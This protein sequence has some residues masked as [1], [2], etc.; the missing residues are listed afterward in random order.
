MKR[1]H[2]ILPLTIFGLLVSFGLSACNGGGENKSA[3]S[4]TVQQSI[5]ITAADSKTKL[6]LGE[7]V[8]LTASVDGVK[9]SSSD[10]N[11]ATISEK[12]L[13]TSLAVGKTTIKATKDGYKDGSLTINVDLQT[14]N[15]TAS[16]T[17]LVKGEKIT[18]TADQQGVKWE[19]ADPAI[20]TVNDS[21]EVTG[22]A[23]GTVAIKASK[24]GFN[25]GSVSITVTRPAPTATLHMEDADHY[26]ADGMWG[27]DYNGTIY[28]PGDESPVYERT[29][30]NASDGK[31]IAYM[32]NGDKEILTF[33][34]SVAV[35]A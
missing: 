10:L 3:S 13:V 24:D 35:K 29:S 27:T 5:K 9:W 11:V 32:D 8:Q 1:K 2:F 6:I 22:V 17:S 16:A 21:G 25:P 26:T 20:A 19:S 34:S 28:G 31:C 18:V 7:T 15:V 4:Q 33:N 23:A 14:T 12:G 30:G